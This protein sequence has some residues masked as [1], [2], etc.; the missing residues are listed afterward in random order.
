MKLPAPT[1]TQITPNVTY[2]CHEGG[3]NKIGKLE[4]LYTIRLQKPNRNQWLNSKHQ[5]VKLASN[6][7]FTLHLS[8]TEEF[9]QILKSECSVILVERHVGFGTLR[10][11]SAKSLMIRLSVRPPFPCMCTWS[12]LLAS[13]VLLSR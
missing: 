7:Q 10:W 12:L 2:L 5:A 3:H 11:V 8:A 6:V 9:P 1:V 13:E 4:S